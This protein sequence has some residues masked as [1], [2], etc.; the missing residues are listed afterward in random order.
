MRHTD[1]QVTRES[2]RRSQWLVAQRQRDRQ[3]QAESAE[4]ADRRTAHCEAQ[5]R[6]RQPRAARKTT[7]QI[8]EN[9]RRRVIQARAL[10]SNEM[11]SPRLEGKGHTRA[12]QAQ[13]REC[14]D[15]RQ[16]RLNDMRSRM[17]NRL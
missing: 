8:R 4:E 3:R 14:V 7:E 15:S 1:C 6:Y 11:G 16:V 2:E 12:N 10:E 9:Q 17:R 5:R 13:A